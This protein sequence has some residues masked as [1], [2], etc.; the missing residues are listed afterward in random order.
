MIK[1]PVYFDYQVA[2]QYRVVGTSVKKTFLWQI[3]NEILI[4]KRKNDF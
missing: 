1:Y 2:N 3:E 4:F